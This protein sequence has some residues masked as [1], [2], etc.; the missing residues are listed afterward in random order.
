M[1]E[2]EISFDRLRIDFVSAA[3]LLSETYWGKDR[4]EG[5]QLDAFSN[6]ICAAAFH[7]SNQIGFGRAITDRRFHAH[8]C[9]IVVWPDWREKG[10]GKRLVRAFLE[11]AE[12]A[13][14]S[15]W[16]LH[17]N[18]A[19]SLYEKFGFERSADGT[20]MRLNR[21]PTT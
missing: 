12:L 11:H 1:I 19:H 15:S 9:D 14:V 4:R 6:S 10:I 17:T 13:R 18:D 7:Q 2:C 3:A 20:Y 16:S 8:L 21:R 5:D